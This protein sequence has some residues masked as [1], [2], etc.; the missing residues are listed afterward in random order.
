LRA[1][2]CIAPRLKESHEITGWFGSRCRIHRDIRTAIGCD[3][4]DVPLTLGIFRGKTDSDLYFAVHV[5]AR[6]QPPP[7]D[8][9]LPFPEDCS[10]LV[11]RSQQ[12]PER[13]LA[14]IEFSR[15]GGNSGACDEW[16]RFVT[17]QQISQPNQDKQ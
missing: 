2:G 15:C 6:K 8:R 11:E 4:Q 7:L 14:A 1:E 9:K 17:E 5:E 16:E 12:P 13:N 3:Y 10:V